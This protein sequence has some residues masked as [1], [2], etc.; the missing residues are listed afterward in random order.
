MIRHFNYIATVVIC[1]AT[2]SSFSQESY[3]KEKWKPTGEL[4]V[5]LRNSYSNGTVEKS[6]GGDEFQL[7]GGVTH[8]FR[9]GYQLNLPKNLGVQMRVG[10]GFS[11]MVFWDDF[12]DLVVWPQKPRNYFT[13]VN[14]NLFTSC[15]F[16]LNYTK[17]LT[18]NLNLTTLGGVG[19]NFSNS[20]PLNYQI[21]NG[22]GRTI[23]FDL[24]YNNLTK[25][26]LF[27]ELGLIRTLK[28]RNELALSLAYEYSFDPIYSGNYSVYEGNS[29]TS[30][31]RFYN[32]GTNL[33]VS[34]AYTF[35]REKARELAKR[36]AQK[37]GTSLK[38]EK[39]NLRAEK[40]AVHPKSI[41]FGATAGLFFTKNI[42]K[43][44]DSPF[45]SGY[46][47]WWSVNGFAEIGMKNNY[48]YEIGVGFEEYA[49]GVSFKDPRFWRS[50]SN[51]YIASKFS[52]GLGRRFIHKPSNLKL[53]N[54]HAGLGLILTYNTNK[55]S[56]GSSGGAFY[57]QNDTLSYLAIDDYKLLVAPTLYVVLE[58]DFQ[59]SSSLFAS[60]RY[61]YDQG[62][63]P[64]FKQDIEYTF[65]GVSGKTKNLVYGTSQ[66]FGVAI[67]YKF[68]QKKYRED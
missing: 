13:H 44:S 57:R 27:F 50:W 60:V 25:P 5:V 64:M 36:N 61:R 11:P 20:Y 32:N 65:N 42:I 46:Y 6:F 38:T 2:F 4:S 16:G 26:I 59:L 18:N 17:L 24:N 1:A 66:T 15:E 34:L 58:K 67:K 45:Q 30:S 39:K 53:I 9:L 54:I 19:F 41:F 8:S 33:G 40:R 47:P 62:I 56:G 22:E 12:Y 37:K 43:D 10:F 31:G 63:F 51:M 55:T 29:L 52:G 3:S 23:L 48:F 49:S 14:Y 35:T 28:N 7:M 68:L 21:G